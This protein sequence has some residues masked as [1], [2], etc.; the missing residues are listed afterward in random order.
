MAWWVSITPEVVR[1]VEACGFKDPS[2][3]SVLESVEYHL[4]HYGET[5]AMER[6]HK[7]PEDFFIYSHVLIEG[8][9]FHTLE[10][11]VNDTSAEAG[12]LRIVWVEHYP[13]DFL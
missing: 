7:C 11:L 9:R 10:F 6:W 2:P 3:A 8:G 12:V 1:S 13:G 4:A 5:G